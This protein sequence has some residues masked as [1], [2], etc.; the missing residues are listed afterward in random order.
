MIA[1]EHV[2]KASDARVRVAGAEEAM[3]EALQH[4]AQAPRADKSIISGALETA[5]AELKAAR[6]AVTE[7]EELLARSA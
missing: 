2:Q 3:R 4:L 5:F 1:P 7:L 6:L